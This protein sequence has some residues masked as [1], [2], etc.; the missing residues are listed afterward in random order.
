[1]HETAANISGSVQPPANLHDPAWG[2]IPTSGHGEAP[3]RER[4]HSSKVL[5]QRTY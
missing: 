1:M 5:H 4:A 3:Q 2:R